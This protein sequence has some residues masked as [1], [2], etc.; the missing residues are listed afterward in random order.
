MTDTKTTQRPVPWLALA[1][2]GGFWLI[3]VRM[4]SPQWSVYDQYNYGWAVPFLCAYLLW[5][6]WPNRPETGTVH[7]LPTITILAICALLLL[8]TRV[9]VEANPIWR[10]GS[11][12]MALEL[13]ILTLGMVYL[14]GGKSWLRHFGFPVVFF[15]IAVPWPSLWEGAVVQNLMRVNTAIVVEALTALGVPALAHGN[16]IEIS[17]GLV[18]ID[19]ACSGIRS[20]QAT[21]MIAL[22]FG[23]LYRLRVA[24]RAWLVVAGVALALV[25]NLARTFVL[26]W[27]CTKSGIGALDKWHDPTGI[28][29]LLVCFG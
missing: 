1:G 28:A 29:I 24:R 10:A 23:E 5:Q 19:E 2:L 18:G 3:G 22:F 8:P 6:R 12:A 20:L 26:V 16:V 15:L 13:V 25:S 11:W 17:T 4:L 7:L 27:V 9:I 21:L 14:A